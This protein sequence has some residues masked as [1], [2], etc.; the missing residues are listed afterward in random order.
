[1]GTQ[2][3]FVEYDPEDAQMLVQWISMEEWPFHGSSK[4]QQEKK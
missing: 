1:M 3:K 4:P 2:L